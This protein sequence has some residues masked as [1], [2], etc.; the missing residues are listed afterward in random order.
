MYKEQMI[1]EVNKMLDK[2]YYE[3][4]EFFRNMMHRFLAKTGR[5]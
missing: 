2:M 4:V 1:Q 3:D 5:I